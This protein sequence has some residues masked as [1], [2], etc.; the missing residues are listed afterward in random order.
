MDEKVFTQTPNTIMLS[1]NDI[2][3]KLMY[4]FT[5]QCYCC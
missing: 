2:L 3:F 4:L 5:L 1:M